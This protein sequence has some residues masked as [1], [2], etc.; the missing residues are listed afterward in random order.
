MRE[1]WVGGSEGG[2]GAFGALDTAAAADTILCPR[3][4]R[5]LLYSFQTLRFVDESTTPCPTG[6]GTWHKILLENQH[7]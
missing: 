2:R 1:W 3:Y 7:L 6:G 4:T 5:T